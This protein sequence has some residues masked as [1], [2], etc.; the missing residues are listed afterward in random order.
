MAPIGIST[1]GA[2]AACMAANFPDR[3]I[4]V[5][6]QQIDT[7]HIHVY[8]YIY[9]TLCNTFVY[10]YNVDKQIYIY[11]YIYSSDIGRIYISMPTYIYN[12][13]DVYI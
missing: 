4:G 11:I 10:T 1:G 2:Y 9:I 7:K 3:V 13:Y 5:K 12:R 8:I 6:I